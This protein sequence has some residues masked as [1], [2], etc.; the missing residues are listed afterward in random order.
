MQRA[1]GSLSMGFHRPEDP[2]NSSLPNPER[3]PGSQG[4]GQKAAAEA[5]PKEWGGEARRVESQSP[6]IS[7][8]RPL[9]FLSSNGSHPVIVWTAKARSWGGRQG[10]DQPVGR[11]RRSQRKCPDGH[12]QLSRPALP[13]VAWTGSTPSLLPPPGW[14]SLHLL[15]RED[16]GAQDRLCRPAKAPRRI[17]MTP[18]PGSLPQPPPPAP[19]IQQTF[20]LH[21]LCQSQV[22][23]SYWASLTQHLPPG[24]LY[25]GSIPLHPTSTQPK[26]P[27]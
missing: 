8:A 13:Q 4:P 6:A 15:L 9:H 27:G 3:G 2:Q 26:I 7:T 20:T 11:E 22:S 23:H 16:A 5:G 19:S 14:S 18:P 1:R 17:E 24:L 25:S 12:G 10:L 21:L